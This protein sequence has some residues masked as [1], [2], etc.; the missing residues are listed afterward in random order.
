[1]SKQEY[2]SL[3]LTPAQ[4]SERYNEL[5]HP[6]IDFESDSVFLVLPVDNGKFGVYFRPQLHPDSRYNTPD[7]GVNRDVPQEPVFVGTGSAKKTAESFE[8]AVEEAVKNISNY[9]NYEANYNVAGNIKAAAAK[10]LPML[11]GE[12]LTQVPVLIGDDSLAHEN[13]RIAPIKDSP[14]MCKAILNDKQNDVVMFAYDGE[15]TVNKAK[16]TGKIFLPT[17]EQNKQYKDRFLKE[18]KNNL[19]TKYEDMENLIMQNE[20]IINIWLDSSDSLSP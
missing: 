14:V 13:L 5:V 11:N 2:S 19:Q 6:S 8:I 18:A 20:E 1:M 7:F 12:D 3:T 10:F 15:A 16:E 4:M 9:E 17:D